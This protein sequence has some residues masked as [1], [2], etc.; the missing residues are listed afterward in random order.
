MLLFPT[1]DSARPFSMLGLGDIVIP[2][3]LTCLLMRLDLSTYFFFY[4]S[5]LFLAFAYDVMPALLYIVPA[6]IGSLAVH[7]IWNADVKQVRLAY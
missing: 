1:A 5:L 3:R 6:V 4:F 7:C 2:V